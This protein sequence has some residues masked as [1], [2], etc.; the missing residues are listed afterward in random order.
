MSV[1][2]ARSRAAR[3][4]LHS[5]P[6]E[7]IA[8][9]CAT[10]RSVGDSQI[11]TSARYYG[12]PVNFAKSQRS[13]SRGHGFLNAPQPYVVWPNLLWLGPPPSIILRGRT[14]LYSLRWLRVPARRPTSERERSFAKFTGA[15]GL[16]DSPLQ[17]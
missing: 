11:A 16:S 10:R 12:I 5:K 13:G 7:R 4:F 3:R 17:S 14:V 1:G 6:L 2:L 9:R 15:M 8:R